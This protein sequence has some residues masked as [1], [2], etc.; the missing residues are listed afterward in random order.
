MAKIK[1][2][3]GV[4]HE[5]S[6]IACA[7]QS[8][9]IAL[10]VERITETEYFV[11]EQYLENPIEGFLIIALKRHAKSVTDFTEE[12]QKDFMKLLVQCRESMRVQLDIEKVT[13]VQEE[14]SSDS[15]FHM[16]LFPWLPW[17]SD[18]KNR[19]SNIVEVMKVAKQNSTEEELRKV[20]E[21]TRKLKEYFLLDVI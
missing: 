5:V 18:Y 17:M 11:V 12:E 20:K 4:E 15:H 1:D 16:W 13:L 19:I 2:I 10:P 21:A 8:G 14:T 3:G 9:V 7:I 6:C